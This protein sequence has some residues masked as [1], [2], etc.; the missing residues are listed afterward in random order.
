[1]SLSQGLVI[2]GLAQ[3]KCDMQTK[4]CSAYMSHAIVKYVMAA[5]D[6]I[7]FNHLSN[8]NTYHVM[9]IKIET[10]NY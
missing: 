2:V 8:N 6:L 9:F 10:F 4:S 1:M 5:V 7:I 3:G